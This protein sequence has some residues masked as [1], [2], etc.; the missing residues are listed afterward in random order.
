MYRTRTF[1][2]G[3]AVCALA[4]AA[5]SHVTSLTDRFV[6]SA[7]NST[8]DSAGKAAAKPAGDALGARM[9][10]AYSPML[11]QAYMSMVFAMAFSSGGYAVSGNDYARGQYTRWVTT[12]HG[13]KEKDGS[14]ERAYL[15]DDKEGNAW[16]KVKWVLDASKPAD[17][18]II[19]EALFD[20]RNFTMLRLRA[21]MPNETE[22]KEVP[23]TEATYYVPPQR[24]TRQSIEGAT[25]ATESVSVPAG[26]FTAR[27]VVY[28][29][30]STSSWWLVD[31]VPGGAVKVLHQN[32]NESSEGKRR[33]WEMAL[34]AYGTGAASELGIRP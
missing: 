3:A 27:K 30:G 11:A 6:G 25:V 2:L 14:L 4:L 23:V 33:G 21:K 5:C 20:K 22:G 9:A 28:G 12:S 1:Q 18:T 8:A 26:S 17:S 31:K 24:L 32:A 7:I 10:D 15:F 29:G 13:E 16:W 19:I 34:T